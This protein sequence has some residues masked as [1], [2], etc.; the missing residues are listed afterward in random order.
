MNL[1]QFKIQQPRKLRVTFAAESIFGECRVR[2]VSEWDF[3]QSVE[4]LPS[5]RSIPLD[6]V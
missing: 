5:G 4:I 1:S 2:R 3:R 6:N